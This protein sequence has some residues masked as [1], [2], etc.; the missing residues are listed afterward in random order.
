MKTVA[1]RDCLVDEGTV[2]KPKWVVEGGA[3]WGGRSWWGCCWCARRREHERRRWGWRGLGRRRGR[4]VRIW[5]RGGVNI[6][7]LR[8]SIWSG[9]VRA[10]TSSFRVTDAK[11]G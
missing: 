1:T 3:S 9:S 4:R 8:V 7:G 10:E 5:G 6:G 2:W 11:E